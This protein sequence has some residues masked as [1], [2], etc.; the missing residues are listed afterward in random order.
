MDESQALDRLRAILDAPP[1]R[2]TAQRSL[3]E[4]L[5]AALADL[6]Y[7]LW[8]RL[9]LPTEQT[10]GEAGG[11]LRLLA[12]VAAAAA[13][14]GVALYVTQAV[15]LNLTGETR[16]HRA[17]ARQRERSNELWRQAQALAATGDFAGAI[18]PLYR[19]A[20]SALHERGALPLQEALTN[21][22]YARRA[23]QAS[24]SLGASFAALVD[25]YDGLRYGGHP[26][27]ADAFADLSRLVDDLRQD[28]FSV[29]SS[30][31]SVE[32]R[33]PRTGN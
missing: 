6:A 32:P 27:G 9:Q 28:Q 17:A 22:E 31:F 30:Q 29:H 10:A 23:A 16:L 26:V 13:L 21:R 24:P 5:W 3:L 33:Q 19:S 7:T 1:F 14:A 12:L 25:R 8:L 18:V 11:W 15:R 4:R 2:Q 20:L